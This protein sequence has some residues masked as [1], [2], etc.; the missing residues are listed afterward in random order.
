MLEQMKH[1]QRKESSMRYKGYRVESPRTK[2]FT[3]IIGKSDKV[4]S[5]REATVS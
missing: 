4:I 5:V 1:M 2:L 3:D